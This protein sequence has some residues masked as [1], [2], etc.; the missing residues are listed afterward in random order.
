MLN[1]FSGRRPIL[2]KSSVE[3]GK[4]TPEGLSTMRGEVSLHIF[5]LTLLT[6]VGVVGQICTVLFTGCS[7]LGVDSVPKTA[8]TPLGLELKTRFQLILCF[9]IQGLSV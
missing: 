3:S 6:F 5:R 4:C 1:S 7:Y 8:L 9:Q 2:P